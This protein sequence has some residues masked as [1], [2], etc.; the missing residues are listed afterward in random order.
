MSSSFELTRRLA[1]AITSLG[2]EFRDTIARNRKKQK[3]G[4]P[5]CDMPGITSAV[6]LIRTDPASYVI[7]FHDNRFVIPGDVKID[8]DHPVLSKI[9]DIVEAP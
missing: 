4:A 7:S 9:K 3:E 2:D 1:N 8:W 6:K 5:K